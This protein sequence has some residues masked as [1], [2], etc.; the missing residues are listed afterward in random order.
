MPIG[1]L[2]IV[3]VGTLYPL[4]V[5]ALSGTKLSVGPP[6]FD[7]AAGPLALILVGVMAAGP[8]MRWRRED[9]APLLRRVA[10]GALLVVAALIAVKLA[11]PAIRLLPLLGLALAIGESARTR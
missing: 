6:Y 1:V 9:V 5:E 2:G 8:L 11:A 4:I 7:A 3:L 10:P